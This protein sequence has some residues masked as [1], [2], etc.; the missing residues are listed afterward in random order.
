MDRIKKA[1]KD[2]PF[3]AIAVTVGAVTAASALLNGISKVIGSTGYAI[4]AAKKR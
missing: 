3:T 2:D 4:Y 1:F